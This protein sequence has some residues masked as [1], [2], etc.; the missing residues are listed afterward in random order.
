MWGEYLLL[1]KISIALL[2]MWKIQNIGKKYFRS[3]RTPQLKFCSGLQTLL[4]LPEQLHCL[5]LPR[6]LSPF[7]AAAAFE[8]SM[9]LYIVHRLHSNPPPLHTSG[10]KPIAGAAP[11]FARSRLVPTLLG[12]ERA[13]SPTLPLLSVQSRLNSL[14]AFIF[15][16]FH[17]LFTSP[18]NS[19]NTIFY[20][21]S[22]DL[23]CLINKQDTTYENV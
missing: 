13:Q 10:I 4:F 15:F 17:G 9:E 8:C 20:C 14:P 6:L 23:V 11:C 3:C 7:P 19:E 22:V 1:W 18:R 16:S 2:S 5:A 12:R 21:P